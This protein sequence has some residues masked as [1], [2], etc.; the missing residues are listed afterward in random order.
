MDKKWFDIGLYLVSNWPTDLCFGLVAR[1]AQ[2]R[3]SQASFNAAAAAFTSVQEIGGRNLLG[4]AHFR[5]D[6]LLVSLARD[7]DDGPVAAGT[8]RRPLPLADVRPNVSGGTGR[9]CRLG[10]I[11]HSAS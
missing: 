10:P 9:L 1:F 6:G 5:P 2:S 4:V 7:R 8:F 11:A 3:K